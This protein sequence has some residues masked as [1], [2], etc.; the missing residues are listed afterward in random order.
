MVLLVEVK[1]VLQPKLEKKGSGVRDYGA[2][3]WGGKGGTREM[4][5]GGGGGSM[6]NKSTR[7]MHRSAP[8]KYLQPGTSPDDETT[9]GAKPRD[10]GAS[11]CA[12]GVSTFRLVHK[13]RCLSFVGQLPG[14]FWI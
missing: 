5:L 10:L 8:S 2:S 14:R 3:K 7:A 13:F 9:P 6:N 11:I 12:S 1:G 4:G